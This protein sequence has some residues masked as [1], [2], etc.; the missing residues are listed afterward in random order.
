MQMLAKNIHP[1]FNRQRISPHFVYES[2][3]EQTGFFHN[4]GSVGFVLMGNPR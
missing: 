3:D 2:F 1:D 4:K